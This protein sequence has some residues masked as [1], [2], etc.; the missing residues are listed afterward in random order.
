MRAR[1]DLKKLQER[2]A[3][4][5]RNQTRG[6]HGL[7]VDEGSF[8]QFNAPLTAFDT[9][10]GSIHNFGWSVNPAACNEYLD[11]RSGRFTFVQ[12]FLNAQAMSKDF[13]LVRPKAR[14]GHQ[15][16][17]VLVVNRPRLRRGYM[18]TD[19]RGQFRYFGYT[20]NM[21]VVSLI[22]PSSPLSSRHRGVFSTREDLETLADSPGLQQHLINLYFEYQEPA[23][24][25]IQKDLFMSDW[26]RGARGQYFS[27][28]LLH[29]VL[30]RSAR[31]SDNPAAVEAISVYSR[32][33][34]ADLISELDDP[35]LATIQALCIYGHFLG[36]LGND[37]GCWLYPGMLNDVSRLMCNAYVSAGMAFRLLY[38]FGLH[39][40]CLNLVQSGELTEKDRQVRLT[41]LWGC[42]VLDK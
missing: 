15:D 28:F 36:S 1:A 31:L 20:S 26:A 12:V 23:L 40:D 33:A 16:S 18:S 19:E 9:L 32:R 11:P 29:V 24:P 5:E 34:K 6:L 37:R 41:T 3:V 30:G 22:P 27:R 21:Q 2:I 7:T 8:S 10:N 14:F 35:T 38:D 13:S 39:Q 17:T 42:Y 4:L 25:I